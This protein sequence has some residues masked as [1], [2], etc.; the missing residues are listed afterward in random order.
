MES[1]EQLVLNS[2]RESTRKVPHIT[3]QELGLPRTL[4]L[5][6]DLNHQCQFCSSV[7]SYQNLRHRTAPKELEK[8]FKPSPSSNSFILIKIYG[9][10]LQDDSSWWKKLT[11]VAAWLQLSAS[12]L[13]SA[14]TCALQPGPEALCK[15][16]RL[17]LEAE[18]R[19][20]LQVC[21]LLQETVTS[22]RKPMQRLGFECVG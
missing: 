10:K 12:L 22:V 19:F 13:L 2:R 21:Y 17:I 18:Q 9:Y 15:H 11:A 5:C 20:L 1:E 16:C 6:E 14:P 7:S 8:T 4:F 3:Q